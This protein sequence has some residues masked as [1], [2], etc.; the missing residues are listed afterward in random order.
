MLYATDFNDEDVYDLQRLIDLISNY[1]PVIHCLHINFDA[2][3]S[4]DI[5]KNGILK[6]TFQRKE[7]L[8][9]ANFQSYR[10]C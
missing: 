6:I 9:E 8:W 1:N 4:A 2:D 5:E 3:H 7:L 10:R